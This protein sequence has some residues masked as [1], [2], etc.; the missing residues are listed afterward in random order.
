M[1]IRPFE[2]RAASSGG[3]PPGPADAVR[4]IAVDD[5]LAVRLGLTDLLGEESDIE[6]VGVAA[7][8][9]ELLVD[10]LRLT[11]DVVVVDYHLGEGERDGLALC[12]MLRTLPRPPR[13]LIYSAYADSVLTVRAL[14]AG[15]H[16][17][18]SKGSLGTEVSWAIHALA[19]GRRVLPPIA[20]PIADSL[21][22]RLG[23]LDQAIFVLILEGAEDAEIAHALDLGPELLASRRKH[24]TRVLGPL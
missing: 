24:M 2:R 15:A 18:I 4:V 12:L 19:N 9:R 22:E 1:T 16:G 5:H 7:G 8:G 23:P 17:V 11:P 13:V 10:A 3:R 21:R 20:P 6:L 14:V